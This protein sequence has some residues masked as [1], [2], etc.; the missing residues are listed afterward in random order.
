MLV[1]DAERQRRQALGFPPFGGLAEVSGAPD[2]VGAACAAA[3]AAGVTVL[4]PVVDGTRA[5]LRALSRDALCD[6]LATPGV[7]AARSRGRLRIDVDPRRV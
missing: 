7:D 2:A 4:G 3:G 5:L 1:A 6:A